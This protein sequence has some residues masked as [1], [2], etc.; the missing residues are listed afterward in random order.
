MVRGRARG[1]FRILPVIDPPAPRQSVALCAAAH[2]LPHAARSRAG[3]GQRMESR[4]GLG[5]VD[6]VLRH[7]FFFQ[8]LPDH[9]FIPAGARQ[10]A[11]NRA[12]SAGREVVDKARDLVGHH[13]RQVG[14][15]G[16]DLGFGLCFYA[17]IDRRCEFVGFVDGRWFRLLLGKPIPLLQGGKFQIIDAVQNAVEFPL[18]P[19]VGAEVESAAQQLVKCG[20][21][22]LLGGFEMAG[23][24]VILTG[25]VLFFDPGDQVGDGVHCER[26]RR[27]RLRWNFIGRRVGLLMRIRLVSGCCAAC[28]EDRS[29][30]LPGRDESILL[31]TLAANRHRQ[32][33]RQCREQD[34][35]IRMR[36]KPHNSKHLRQSTTGKPPLLY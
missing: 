1:L 3:N 24:I 27:L 35:P 20:V 21:E 14:T 9:V 12:P 10:R 16:L 29:L 32:N 13:Q 19:V 28:C 2:E 25:L 26:L 17:F 34:G 7:S 23:M 5:Q 15:S 33:R 31:R 11:F 8:D 4:F 18:Q 30:G 6:Q 36:K 22:I